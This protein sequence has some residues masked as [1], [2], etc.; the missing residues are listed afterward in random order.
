MR[1]IHVASAVIVLFLGFFACKKSDNNP[2][3][4]AKTVANFSGQYNLTALQASISRSYH[5]SV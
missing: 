3:A 1:K 4:N 2:P 5:K